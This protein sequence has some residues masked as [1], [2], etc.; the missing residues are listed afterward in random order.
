MSSTA[1]P[2]VDLVADLIAHARERGSIA[3]TELTAA[4]ERCDL[5]AEAV[6]G[7]LKMLADEGVDVTDPAPEADDVLP[8]EFEL[9]DLGICVWR[10]RSHANTRT[11]QM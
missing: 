5:S 9:S 8:F 6:D 4:F 10:T 1:A 2:P 7:V 3:M 11:G